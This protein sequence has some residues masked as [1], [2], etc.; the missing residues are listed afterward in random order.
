MVVYMVL[1]I[2]ARQMELDTTAKRLAFVAVPVVPAALTV[3]AVWRNLRSSDEYQRLTGYWSMSVGFA[4]A[5]VAAVVMAFVGIAFKGDVDPDLGAWV[6]FASG[7][8][9]WL[10]AAL[11]VARRA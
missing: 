4:A 1:L 3:W 6:T 10:V 5:M 7:M 2:A 9:A 11:V 8:G